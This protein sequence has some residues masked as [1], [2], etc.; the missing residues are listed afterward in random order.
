[1]DKTKDLGVQLEKQKIMLRILKSKHGKTFDYITNES[2]KFSIKKDP[3]KA[4][5]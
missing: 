5:V 3:L 1:M 2:E 4:L